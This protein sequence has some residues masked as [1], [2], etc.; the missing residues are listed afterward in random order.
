MKK[1]FAGKMT[2][3]VINDQIRYW[4]EMRDLWNRCEVFPSDDLTLS[5]F[6][7][8]FRLQSV[9]EVRKELKQIGKGNF[10]VSKDITLL[11]QKEHIDDKLLEERV[12]SIQA[13][14]IAYSLRRN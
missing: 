11:L 6:K 13:G 3:D 4:E 2:L 9:E 14:N 1:L 8:Y 10:P 5:T 7:L 12:K